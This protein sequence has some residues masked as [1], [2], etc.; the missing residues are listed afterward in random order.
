MHTCFGQE[1]GHSERRGKW[2]F[3]CNETRKIRDYFSYKEGLTIY[4]I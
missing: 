1:Y 2:G 3:I 4:V